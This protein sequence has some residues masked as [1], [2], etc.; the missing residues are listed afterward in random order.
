ML[1]YLSHFII[2]KQWE[3]NSTKI[4]YWTSII[5]REKQ[6]EKSVNNSQGQLENKQR[7]S[8][9]R[10]TNQQRK[11]WL[12]KGEKKKKQEREMSIQRLQ[13]CNWGDKKN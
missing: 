10:W 4:W 8:W 13:H 11:K 7:N 5:R 9:E 1:L 12:K 2:I 6:G 3:K